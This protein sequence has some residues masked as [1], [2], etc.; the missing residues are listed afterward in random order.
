MFISMVKE[1]DSI[2]STE[3]LSEENI[4]GLRPVAEGGG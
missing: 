4:S 2:K 1:L 3:L